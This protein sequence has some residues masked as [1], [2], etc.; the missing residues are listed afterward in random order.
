MATFFR[1]DGCGEGVDS[2]KKVGFVLKRD[3][4]PAC[5]AIADKFLHEEE[6]L[7]KVTQERFVVERA[8]LIAKYSA[9]GFKLPDV[10]DA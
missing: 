3:Y 9:G 2:P 6:A 4:C 1:C 8:L 5:A 7:R 10:P